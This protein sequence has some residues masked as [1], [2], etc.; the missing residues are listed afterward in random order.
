MASNHNCK[1]ILIIG[2]G[3]IGKIKANKWLSRGYNVYVKDL[4]FS[5]MKL[6][7]NNSDVLDDLSRHYFTIEICTPTNNHLR[8]LKTVIKKYLYSYISI[9]K[10]LCNRLEDLEEIVALLKKQPHLCKNIFVSEQ[11]FYSKILKKL[12]QLESFSFDQARKITINF[13]KDRLKDNENGRFLDNGLLGYGI[14]IPHIIA[15]ISYLGISLEKFKKGIFVNNLYIKDP[16]RHDYSIEILSSVN[17]SV[18]GVI[19]NLGSFAVRDGKIERGDARTVRRVTIDDKTIIFDP[20]PQLERYK[21]ELVTGTNTFQI[22]DDMMDTYISLL[23]GNSI[24]KG[25]YINNAIEMTKLFMA[26]YSECNKIYL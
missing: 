8:A 3:K 25:C 23:E 9:E 26:L 12:L 11:Y 10:P 15:V 4:K 13:S 19:S 7:N 21:S 5:N 17:Q 22:H 6:L 24:P 18:I 2:F 1:N 14:E 16:D 20:H